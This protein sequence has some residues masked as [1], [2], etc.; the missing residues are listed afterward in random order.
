MLPLTDAIVR[1][2][3]TLPMTKE[4][5]FKMSG[6]PRWKAPFYMIYQQMF[7]VYEAPGV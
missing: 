2:T 1:H 3:H 4:Y 7:T 5:G 6:V